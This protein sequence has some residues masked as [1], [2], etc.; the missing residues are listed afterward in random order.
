M[1]KKYCAELGQAAGT[2]VAVASQK[3]TD[4]RNVDIKCVQEILRKDGILI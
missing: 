1:L 2:A 3:G 4:V